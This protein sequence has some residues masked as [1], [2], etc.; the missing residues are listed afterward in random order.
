M[1]PSIATSELKGL[2][3]KVSIIDIR[4]KYMY[5]L[6]CIPTAKNVPMNFLITNP[7]DYINKNTRYYIYCQYGF[8]TPK[9]C[10]KLNKIG[11]DVVNVMG[12]YND[13]VKS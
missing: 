9:V 10:Y 11:Y 1:Y 13:Y 5:D 2:I 4:D 3:G 6:G 7:D 12:G 8:L